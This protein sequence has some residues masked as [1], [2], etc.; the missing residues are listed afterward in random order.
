VY[1]PK[2]NEEKRLDILHGLIRSQPFATLVTMGS[3]GLVATHLPMVLSPGEGSPDILRG[4]ISR[5]NPQWR[6]FDP[7]I[8]AL[9]IFAGPQH[10][11]TPN[12]YPEKAENGKVV[13]TWNYAVVHAHGRPRF[14]DDR[15]FIETVVGD[16]VHRY[17]GS[18]ARP[19]RIDDQPP[20]FRDRMLAGIV[21]FE[22]PVL[23]IEA[24]FKLGQ[25]RRVEDRAGTIA[26]LEREQSADGLAL[27][28]FMRAHHGG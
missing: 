23:E 16:L 14:R 10:Y 15:P 19:W 25:N 18:R 7:S 27:A 24:K 8:E 1:I 4:H 6:E 17:E 20:D 11:I 12:W 28:H 21:G 22:M 3:T 9:A 5:A 2:F 26:G 13:P